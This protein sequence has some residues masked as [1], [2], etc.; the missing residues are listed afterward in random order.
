MQRVRYLGR[1]IQCLEET[2]MSR[3]V[4]CF[5][6]SA[7]M[8]SSRVHNLTNLPSQEIFLCIFLDQEYEMKLNFL[9]GF[10]KVLTKTCRAFFLKMN[11]DLRNVL[12]LQGRQC[13]KF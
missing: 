1:G 4:V 11:S 2:Q 5:F 8:C 6:K 9:L 3:T 7:I 13:F 12:S 10:C